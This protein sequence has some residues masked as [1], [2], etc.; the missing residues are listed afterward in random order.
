[1]TDTTHGLSELELAY[2]A[3]IGMPPEKYAALK[4]AIDPRTGSWTIDG[5]RAALAALEQRREAREQAARDL[6]VEQEKA[7]L[8]GGGTQ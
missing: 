5:T 8:N 2:A 6:L 3:K 4:S 7:N 1:M